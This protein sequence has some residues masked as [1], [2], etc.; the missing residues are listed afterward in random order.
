MI[1]VNSMSDLFHSEVP[2]CFIDQV[3]AVMLLANQH[4]YQ[5]LTKRVERMLA[6]LSAPERKERILRQTRELLSTGGEGFSGHAFS[7]EDI[8]WPLPNVWLGASIEDKAAAEKRV[9]ELLR[10]PAAV[11]WVSCEPLIGQVNL[12]DITLRE[13][14]SLDALRGIDTTSQGYST[15]KLDWVVVGCES[16]Q[17]RRK[18]DID[19]V[20]FLRDQCKQAET[21]FFLKQLFVDGKMV[22]CPALDGIS[23]AQYPKVIGA[24]QEAAAA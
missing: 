6:Y 8:P 23:W 11:H 18:L 10:A 16:G 21:P 20:R 24:A 17:Q 3:F 19:W 13:G 12:S 9:H 22:G 14:G 1:F 2:D 4:I 5:I 15:S 7:G